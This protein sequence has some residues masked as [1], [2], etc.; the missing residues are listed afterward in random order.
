ME[1]GIS[2]PSMPV[3]RIQKHVVCHV[4]MFTN[5]VGIHQRFAKAKNTSSL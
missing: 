5:H 4:N 2:M 3:I 1:L